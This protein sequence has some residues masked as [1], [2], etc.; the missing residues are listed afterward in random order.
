MAA[1]CAIDRR[2]ARCSDYECSNGHTLHISTTNDV[3]EV[4][5]WPSVGVGR[6]VEVA[7]NLL[8]VIRRRDVHVLDVHAD[9]VARRALAELLDE[10][11]EERR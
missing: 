1:L 8:P 3:A 9:V 4:T 7:C 2:G 11:D 5:W 10:L 6:V